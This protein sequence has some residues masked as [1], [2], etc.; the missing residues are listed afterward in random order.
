MKPDKIQLEIRKNN[1][2]D[3]VIIFNQT[4]VE[5]MDSQSFV[6]FRSIPQVLSN[7]GFSQ[8]EVLRIN[9]RVMNAI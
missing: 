8:A 5:M 1:N 4:L 7:T 6:V 9:T 2:R 3:N